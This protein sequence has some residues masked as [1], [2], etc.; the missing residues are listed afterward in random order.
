MI[1]MVRVTAQLGAWTRRWQQDYGAWKCG[2][3]HNFWVDNGDVTKMGTP[4]ENQVGRWVMSSVVDAL[5]FV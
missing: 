2:W 3:C 5:R 1:V 4:K